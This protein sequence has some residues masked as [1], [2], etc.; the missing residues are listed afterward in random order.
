[1]NAVLAYLQDNVRDYQNAAIRELYKALWQHNRVILQLATGAGKSWI[2]AAIIAHAN[3]KGK[4]A[5][6][7]VDRL[8]LLDQTL[9]VFVKLGLHP[10]VIQGDSTSYQ[11]GDELVVASAQTLEKWTSWPD[12]DVVIVDEVHDQ[13]RAINQK[14]L[15]W[16]NT[17]WIGLTA[18]PFTVGLGNTWETVVR[19]PSTAELI[20][21]GHLSHFDAW[22]IPPDVSNVKISMGDFNQKQLGE[23]VNT[24]QLTGNILKHHQRLAAGEKTLVFCVDIAHSKAICSRFQEAGIAAEHIDYRAD[25]I[26]KHQILQ[27][28]RTGETQVLCSV[29]M[30]SKGFDVKDVGCVILAR[31]TKSLSLYLQQVG[32]GLR[33][34]EG[35]E[36]CIILD[37]A[38]NCSRF[39]LP[40]EDFDRPL[41]TKEKGVSSS[42]KAER[43]EPKPKECPKCTFM[44][45]AGQHECPNC[46]FK[47]ERQTEVTETDSVLVQ[48]RG[49]KNKKVDRARKQAI[50]SQLLM[51]AEANGY[52]RGFASH[53]YR[54]IFDCWPRGLQDTLVTP[55]P[56]MESWLKSR[57]IAFAKRRK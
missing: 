1:M 51:Y 26:E 52:S 11:W 41:C 40:D 31:P 24:D 39:G 44:K 56:Q 29:A 20:R 15:E 37:H 3:S 30:L 34:A 49:T 2:A 19:G 17:K 6:F 18:T 36:R 16:N 47:P 22:G 13:R 38:G 42:D 25:D 46:G 55:T 32:R 8:S 12:V 4:K 9:D 43:E 10:S 5:L 27:R 21:L 35:K 53:K 48:L 14:A 33:A 7:I 57:R 54:E 23:T 45:P 50:W 28:F